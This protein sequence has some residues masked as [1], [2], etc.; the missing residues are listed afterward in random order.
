[1]EE[2]LL[3]IGE[4]LPRLEV[5][6]KALGLEAGRIAKTLVRDHATS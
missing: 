1:M 6:D 5:S 3:Q 4:E 2:R